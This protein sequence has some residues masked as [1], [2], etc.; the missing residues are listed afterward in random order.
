MCQHSI[1]LMFNVSTSS[2]VNDRFAP[3][4]APPTSPLGTLTIER[5]VCI[6]LLRSP[7]PPS[8]LYSQP[9]LFHSLPH[10]CVCIRV[11]GYTTRSPFPV[12]GLPCSRSGA[13][14]AFAFVFLFAFMFAVAFTTAT[15][16]HIRAK[17]G[18]LT[19]SHLSRVSYLETCTLTDN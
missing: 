5:S 17:P 10:V 12:P 13:L 7:T 16:P 14:L 1:R 6:G 3:L 18:P 11:H 15:L 9:P 4:A 8:R 2:H 19:P